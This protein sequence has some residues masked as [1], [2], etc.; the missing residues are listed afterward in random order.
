M[1]CQRRPGRGP[2]GWRLLS[3]IPTPMAAA[4]VSWSGPNGLPNMTTPAIT[5]TSGSMLMKAPATSALTRL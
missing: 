1:D 4:P 5:P 2:A 3:T